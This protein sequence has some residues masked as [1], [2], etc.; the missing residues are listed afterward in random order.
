MLRRSSCRANP[1]MR[2]GPA[3]APIMLQLMR[4]IPQRNSRILFVFLEVPSSPANYYGKQWINWIVFLQQFFSST[5]PS[6]VIVPAPSAFVLRKIERTFNW[7]VSNRSSGIKSRPKLFSRQYDRIFS[8]HLKPVRSRI[9][10][11]R[12]IFTHPG[13]PSE[14]SCWIRSSLHLSGYIFTK[15]QWPSLT[16]AFHCDSP[17]SGNSYF[18]ASYSSSLFSSFF[19]QAFSQCLLV[20]WC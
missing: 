19:S 9:P 16:R 17:L 18:K 14:S 5:Q 20:K 13:K 10:N 1:S 4:W 2:N 6:R 3:K 15:I 12:R 7:R 8:D 11:R